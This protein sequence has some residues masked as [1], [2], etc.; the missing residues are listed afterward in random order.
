MAI[1]PPFTNAPIGYTI[2]A[3]DPAATTLPFRQCIVVKIAEKLVK[4]S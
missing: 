1:K 4:I 2:Y 3:P